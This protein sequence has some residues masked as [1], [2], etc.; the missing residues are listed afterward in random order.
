MTC[1]AEQ[2]SAMAAGQAARQ[3][4]GPEAAAVLSGRTLVEPARLPSGAS[5]LPEALRRLACDTTLSLVVHQPIA[6]APEASAAPPL[7]LLDGTGQGHPSHDRDAP[8]PADTKHPLWV[9]RAARNVTAAQWRAL[10]VR[11]RHCAVR[12]CHRRPAQCQA[13]HVRH[14]LD[15]GL[16]DLDNLVLLCHQ[17]HH[18]HHD[19]GHDLQHA[20]GRWITQAGWADDPPG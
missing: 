5:V 20:D 6:P 2:L 14:W 17:H 19:R 10:V 4:T 9:G 3:L 7:L 15:G 12:G 13:H 16:T 8:S 11:D 18:D 1:T